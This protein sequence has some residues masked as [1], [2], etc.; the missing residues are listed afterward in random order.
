MA[1]YNKEASPMGMSLGPRKSEFGPVWGPAPMHGPRTPG[2]A[3]PAYK[4][5]V[6]IQTRYKVYMTDR[7]ICHLP[8]KMKNP[9][10][11]S[12]K[13]LTLKTFLKHDFSLFFAAWFL[14]SHS[15]LKSEEQT[16]T[17]CIIFKHHPQSPHHYRAAHLLGDT[18]NTIVFNWTLVVN[19]INSTVSLSRNNVSVKVRVTLV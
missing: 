16:K 18:K 10:K 5:G 1:V 15:I 17:F 19:F 8:I 13:A 3:K 11:A 9:I 2:N 6:K 12:K 14:S 7:Q 4:Q